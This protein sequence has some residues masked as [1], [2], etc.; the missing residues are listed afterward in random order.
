MLVDDDPAILSGVAGLLKDEG[1]RT[2]EALNAQSAREALKVGSDAPVALVLDIRMPKESG[3]EFLESL[4][5]PLP[6]PVIV[7]SG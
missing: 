3:L 6:L 7:L 5:K 1:Y 2:V 4:P